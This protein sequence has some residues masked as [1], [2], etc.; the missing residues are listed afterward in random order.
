MTISRRG[1][2]QDGDVGDTKAQPG[3]AGRRTREQLEQ[4]TATKARER[5]EE[6]L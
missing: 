6:E 3:K 5:G 4:R 1:L 2:K